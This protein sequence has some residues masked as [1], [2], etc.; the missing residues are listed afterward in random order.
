VVVITVEMVLTEKVGQVAT[1]VEM[2]MLTGTVAEAWV[3]ELLEK[4]MVAVTGQT[5]VE[6]G[7]VSTTITVE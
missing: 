6:T 5:V 4:L 3:V 7:I 1:E 2:L